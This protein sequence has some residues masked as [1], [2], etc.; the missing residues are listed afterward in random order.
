MGLSADIKKAFFQAMDEDILDS[1][2][3]KTLDKMSKD[4]SKA[5]I[6]FLTS[7]SFTITK[8]KAILEVEEMKTSTNLM[9]DVLPSVIVSTPSGPGS[10]ST[11]TRGVK[12]PPLNI[13][14]F[15]GQGG[16]MKS[17]GHAYIGNNP[18]DSSETNE[19]NTEVKLLKSKVRNK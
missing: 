15:G 8:M 13:R 16:S 14:K 11:G 7:Q 17:K 2:Q 6:D 19:G 18:V 4:L 5:I 12:L 10:V 9:G 1:D 3:K